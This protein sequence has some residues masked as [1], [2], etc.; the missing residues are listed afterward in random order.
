[1]K[2]LVL[3]FGVLGLALELDA[4]RSCSRTSRAIHSPTTGSGS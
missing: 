2:L 3:A 4:L 1:M